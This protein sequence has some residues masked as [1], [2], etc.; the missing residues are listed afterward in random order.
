MDV[1]VAA[2]MASVG[3]GDPGS[4]AYMDV[5][6][7]VD[8]AP[9]AVAAT[10]EATPTL[11]DAATATSSA[12]AAANVA[13]RESSAREDAL[14]SFAEATGTTEASTIASVA[15]EAVGVVAVGKVAYI[16]VR[17]GEAAVV[18]VDSADTTVV[19]EGSAVN[20]EAEGDVTGRS[21]A[22]LG[23]AEV[24]EAETTDDGFTDTST[25]VVGALASDGDARIGATL[26][27]D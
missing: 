25:A 2:T 1:A 14:L 21:P 6:A 5:F 10:G 4:G 12:T 3:A 8:D 11:A 9:V 16:D 27:G 23:A 18:D 15:D 13:A 17:T 22:T 24:L 20:E 26:D 19:E 7:G